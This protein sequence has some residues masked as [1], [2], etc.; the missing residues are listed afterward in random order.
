MSEN[1]Q[2]TCFTSMLNETNMYLITDLS[3][4][5]SILIDPSDISKASDY[6]REHRLKL[7]YILLTHEHYDHICA[8][9]EWRAG[10]PALVV[11]SEPCSKGIHSPGQNLSKVFNLVL[12]FKA[13]REAA[14]T[15]KQRAA[16]GAD[17]HIEPYEAEAADR[18]F[19]GETV[20][21]WQGHEIQI[22]EA[23]GHSRGS[24]LIKIDSQYLFSGDTLSLDY[25]LITRFPG[26]SK[27]DYQKTTLPLLLNME[28]DITVYP[29]HGRSFKMKEISLDS[30]AAGKG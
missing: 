10:C 12:T 15:S 18:I 7:D 16:A 13:E 24:V 5:C 9:N 8:L 21:R 23:P 22:Q 6:L 29:G 11:A 19:Q 27:K 20:L 14:Q 2:V 17:V 1:L 3:G 30:D 26:G 25:E 28:P 4:K